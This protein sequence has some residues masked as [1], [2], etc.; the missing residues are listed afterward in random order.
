MFHFRSNDEFDQSEGT[1]TLLDSILGHKLDTAYWF[2]VSHLD[3]WYRFGPSTIWR[4]KWPLN[5]S[6]WQQALAFSTILVCAMLS[7]WAFARVRFANPDLHH[8]S[9]FDRIMH[10]DAWH[11]GKTIELSETLDIYL[12]RT[13]L[14]SY[15][16][17]F[18]CKKLALLCPSFLFFGWCAKASSFSDFVADIEC[19]QRKY[20]YF[21][22]LKTSRE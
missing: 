19:S 8:I 10:S 11:W 20:F 22:G 4:S 3:Q 15:S 18:F 2:A 9:R 13:F 6:K 14:V 16:S 21:F 7:N 1:V 12:S 5:C 17:I